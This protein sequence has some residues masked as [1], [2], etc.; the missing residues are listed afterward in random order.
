MKLTG[1]GTDTR[2]S[3]HKLPE[4]PASGNS[5]KHF[6][7]PTKVLATSATTSCQLFPSPTLIMFRFLTASS[8][9]ARILLTTSSRADDSDAVAFGS[10]PSGTA[11][12]ANGFT[13]N[14][15]IRPISWAKH[16]RFAC[17]R[18]RR[19]NER[20]RLPGSISFHQRLWLPADEMCVDR[21]GGFQSGRRSTTV[22]MGTRSAT[23]SARNHRHQ[24]NQL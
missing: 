4:Q 11:H 14:A 5:P 8:S 6:D 9:P 16:F 20:E 3:R 13:F 1:V 2:R 10:R 24:L 15:H 7:P 22:I 19:R 12:S 18:S 21:A 23:P 17:P